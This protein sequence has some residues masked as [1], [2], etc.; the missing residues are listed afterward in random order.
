LANEV[1]EAMKF[2][3]RIFDAR[4][5]GPMLKGNFPDR[6]GPFLSYRIENEDLSNG[7]FI[8]NPHN[9]SDQTVL[10]VTFH[11]IARLDAHREAAMIFVG[12]FD[13][14]EQVVGSVRATSMLALNYPAEN[15]DELREQLGSVDYIPK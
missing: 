9:L 7:F 13:P 15:F 8:A 12:G 1:P 10:F 11:K 2:V 6:I 14:P 3:G 5:I 4:L